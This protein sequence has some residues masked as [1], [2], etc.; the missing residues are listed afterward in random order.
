MNLNNKIKW[1]FSC[2][3]TMKKVDE[4]CNI[5]D[6]D[7]L[8]TPAEINQIH[9]NEMDKISSNNI[10][11]LNNIK[12]GNFIP[13]KLNHS[14]T[15]IS[16]LDNNNN[17]THTYTNTNTN[18]DSEKLRSSVQYNTFKCEAKEVKKFMAGST[19]Y[20]ANTLNSNQALNIKSSVSN[21]NF[22]SKVKMNPEIEETLLKKGVGNTNNDFSLTGT[23]V[24]QF[25]LNNKSNNTR[26]K[27]LESIKKCFDGDEDA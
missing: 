25:N 14:S 2:L 26:S 22:N 18:K 1:N 15:I 12:A 10:N 19:S 5:E 20:N 8:N 7:D 17:N 27:K 23:S 13:K 9:L 21:M 3:E 6:D 16:N 4:D 11:N 24:S